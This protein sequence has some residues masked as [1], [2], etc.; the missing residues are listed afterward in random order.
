MFGVT[1]VSRERARIGAA[2]DRSAIGVA[3]ADDALIDQRGCRRHEFVALDS[4]SGRINVR[5][6]C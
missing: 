1:P 5:R 4:I 3:R 2:M 6:H